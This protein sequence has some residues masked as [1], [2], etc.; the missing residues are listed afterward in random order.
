MEVIE[1]K[2]VDWIAMPNMGEEALHGYVSADRKMFTEVRDVLL[3]HGAIDLFG[4]YLIHKHFDISPQ[5]EMVEFVDFERKEVTVRPVNRSELEMA[6]LVPTNWFFDASDEGLGAHVA[7]WGFLD[8]LD[9]AETNPLD[10]KYSACFAEIRRILENNDSLYRFG[11]F[12]VR[13]QFPF[14]IEIN[15]LE[16]TDLA[17]RTLTINEEPDARNDSSSVPTNWVFTP[18]ATVATACCRCAQTS[19]GHGGYH[20]R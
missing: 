15:M 19:Q 14:E 4:L 2:F 18:D 17:T 8:D 10:E 5:E 3:R 12:L 6:N 7:Q 16:C 20:Q 13:N 1:R 11:M 9:H